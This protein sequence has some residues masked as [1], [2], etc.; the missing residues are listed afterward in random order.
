MFTAKSKTTILGVL[1][2]LTACMQAFVSK[3]MSGLIAAVP[4]GLGLIF[5]QDA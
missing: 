1:T 2:L 5:A 4:S 3:D